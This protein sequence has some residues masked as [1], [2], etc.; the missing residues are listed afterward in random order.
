MMLPAGPIKRGSR[1]PAAAAAIDSLAV[2][3]SSTSS[4]SREPW[5]HDRRA[6]PLAVGG[7]ALV[8][9][10]LAH[11]VVW[12]L[13]GGPWEGPVTWR[14][15]ILFGISGGLTSLS[16]G[17]AWARL[18]WRRG[19]LWLA[20]STALALAVEVAVIDLQ[21]WRGVAS[22]FNRATPLDSFLFDA[23]GA[24]IVGVTLVVLDLTVRFVVQRV[25]LPADMRAAA[26]GGLALLAISCLLGIWTGAHG[27]LRQQA[28]LAPELVGAAGVAKFPH[29][30]AIHAIQWLPLVAWVLRRAGVAEAARLRLVRISI[31]GMVL[32]LGYAL[33]QTAAG[34]GRFDVTPPTAVLLGAG[35]VALVLPV[36]VAVVSS[37]LAVGRPAAGARHS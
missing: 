6:W 28:G 8:L 27:E 11:V 5:W 19:D 25:A 2:M 12:G 24:L 37:A 14:K 29:G 30:V 4:T 3:S 15:P 22:H 33:A 23:L 26:R 10:G 34:R 20:W 32:V 16:L 13:L 17:W 7:A 31:L 9:S 36:L 35:L 21:R 1:R 18:P